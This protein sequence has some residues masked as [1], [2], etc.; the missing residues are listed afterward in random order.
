MILKLEHSFKSLS[1]FELADL[2]M[3][4]V[5]SGENGSGKSH[6]LQGIADGT[7][8]GDWPG[9]ANAI[10]LLTSNDLGSPQDMAPGGSG[11]ESIVRQFESTIEDIQH[12]RHN[13]H[14]SD[15]RILD[16]TLEERLV[17]TGLSVATCRE[18]VRRSGK[19]FLDWTHDDFV[20]HTP[21]ELGNGDLFSLSIQDIFGRYN[22]ILTANGVNALRRDAGQQHSPV[23]SE[24]ELEE[25]FGAPPWDLLNSALQVI[26]LNYRW[27]APE[28]SMLPLQTP[29]MLQDIDTHAF[30]PTS[31][32][33]S[34]EKTLLSI[35]LSLYSATNRKGYVRM[36]NVVLLDEP[37]A[38]L[39][40]SMIR[41]LLALLNDHFVAELAIR[42]IMTTHSPTTVALA[43][44]DSLYIMNKRSTPR[45]QPAQ[46]KDGA[47]SMLL[48]GVP[49]ISISADNRRIVVVESP[50]DEKR[51]TSIATILANH[52]PS[53]RS[54]VFMAA[55]STALPSGSAAVLDLVGRLRAN[56]S[57]SV[58]GLID[59]DT[60]RSSPSEYVVFDASRYTAENV[61]LDPLALGYYLLLEA[62][63]PALQALPGITYKNFDPAQ[64]AQRV[65]DYVVEMV[66]PADG[67]PSQVDITYVG[68]N[69]AQV[70]QFWLDEPGHILAKRIPESLMLLRKFEHD[71][72]RLL[73]QIIDRVWAPQPELIPQNTLD[74]LQTLLSLE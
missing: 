66:G 30:Y 1:A 23:R 69:V 24:Q 57:K 63:A 50:Y 47:L 38:T 67:D 60:R 25:A 11:R 49:S 44:A 16:A 33:S 19:S 7:I 28:L 59:R 29:P 6:L 10:R 70:P 56:G 42:V 32:L 52:L 53:E 45:L 27:V 20:R 4:M 40:P 5:V 61:I 51:Y 62:Y 36:P 26:G 18:L 14:Y 65:I 17:N 55:G 72:E 35:A 71:P 48:V 9:G 39:H 68:G 73:T 21:S 3:L 13:P 58:W 41:S 64:D 8:S 12:L 2:P 37:D 22:Q 34:G 43:P 15:P 31:A 54:L 46:S 74:I